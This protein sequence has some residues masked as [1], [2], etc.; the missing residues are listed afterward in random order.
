MTGI[1]IIARLGSKRLE[2]KH[3]INVEGKM[4]IEWLVLRF[5][6][7]FKNEITYKKVKIIIATSIAPENKQFIELLQKYPVDVFFGSDT[8]IPY[9]QL[10]CALNYNFKN[11]ISIDGDDILSSTEASRIIY[12]HLN[13][14]FTAVKTV[15]LPMGMNVIGYSTGYLEECIKK[16]NANSQTMLETGWGRIFNEQVEKINLGEY[17]KDVRLR[18][19][20]DYDDDSVFFKNIISNFKENIVNINDSQLLNY[21]LEKEIFKLNMNLNEIYWENF[22][23]SKNN[24]L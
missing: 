12:N 5:L 18:F 17:E 13:N 4:F 14:G 7:Q 2:K 23:N 1:L 6:N 3:L 21:V 24:E 11:I 16:N 20:L 15:G 10:E 9:R 19:T 8:N 22:N